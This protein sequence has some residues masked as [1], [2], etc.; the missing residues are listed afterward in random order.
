MLFLDR[1]DAAS[2]GMMSPI[3]AAMVNAVALDDNVTFG[4]MNNEDATEPVANE[5]WCCDV[6]E[7]VERGLHNEL[8]SSSD[9][10]ESA[11]KD[12]EVVMVANFADKQEVTKV[13]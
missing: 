3:N 5:T 7:E 8:S 4:G 1:I 11:D 2:A 13:L 12:G 6:T 9:S 10:K